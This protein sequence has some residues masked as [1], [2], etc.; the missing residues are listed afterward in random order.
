MSTIREIRKAEGI[1]Q[2]QLGTLLV[3]IRGG[4]GYQGPISS[5]ERGEVSPTVRRLAD[6]LEALG[7]GIRIEAYKEGRDPIKLDLSMLLGKPSREK[8][9]GPEPAQDSIPEAPV[10]A[11]KVEPS[12]LEETILRA[13]KL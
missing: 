8:Q 11:S 4:N 3:G 5:I 2:V 6:I 13:F 12:S 9:E 7:Y 10:E 1:T